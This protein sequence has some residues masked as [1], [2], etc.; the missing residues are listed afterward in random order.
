M[1]NK[2]NDPRRHHIPRARYKVQNWPEYDRG[3]VQRGDIR[4]WISEDALE[5]W[6]APCR[7]T[8]GGQQKFSNLAI[9]ATLVLGA[10]FKL[11]LRQTEGFVRSL[12]ALLNRDLPVPDHTTLARRRHTVRVDQHAPGRTAPVDLVLDSTGHSLFGAGEKA[13]QKHGEKRRSWRMPSPQTTSLIPRWQE[14]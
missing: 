11:P 7:M 8:P 12:M 14:S 3:L 2:N 5:G 1:P 13:R 9:E 10:V 4:F 6:V